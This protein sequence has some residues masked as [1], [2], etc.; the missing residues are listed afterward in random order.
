MPS[1]QRAGA[2]FQETRAD[3]SNDSVE[4]YSSAVKSEVEPNSPLPLDVSEA[5]NEEPVEVEMEEEPRRLPTEFEL[6]LLRPYA[7][8][9]W[10]FLV[11]VAFCEKTNVVDEEVLAEFFRAFPDA[12]SVEEVGWFDVQQLLSRWVACDVA[13]EELA[14][15]IARTSLDYLVCR[16]DPLVKSKEPGVLSFFHRASAFW[17]SCYDVVFGRDQ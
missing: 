1:N 11:A 13:S 3:V 14:R 7:G 2:S 6:K 12:D 16:K 4:D 17:R 9:L 10:K 15:C 5:R 8:D